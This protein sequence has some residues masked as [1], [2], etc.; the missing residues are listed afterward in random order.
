VVVVMA[1]V[2]VLPIAVVLS[3]FQAHPQERTGMLWHLQG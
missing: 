1:V 3:V 2:V